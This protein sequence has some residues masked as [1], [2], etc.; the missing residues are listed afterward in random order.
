MVYEQFLI[1]TSRLGVSIIPNNEKKNHSII[2][3]L[4][5][6]LFMNVA[7]LKTKNTCLIINNSLKMKIH[8]SSSMIDFLTDWVVFQEIIF[9]NIEFI[10]ILSEV[11]LEWL[12]EISPLY[13]CVIKKVDSI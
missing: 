11:R 9:T 7:R 5:T 1:L 4:C 2:K 10:N 6:G 13:Y 3:C 12:I 8:P